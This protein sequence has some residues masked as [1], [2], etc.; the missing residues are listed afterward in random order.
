M[1]LSRGYLF[2]NRYLLV[3]LLGTG[4]SAQVWKAKDTRANN[5][6]VALKI[7]DEN[8][9]LNSFGLQNF[10]KQFTIVFNMK[11]SNLLPPTGYDIFQGRPYLVMQYCE[12]GSCTSMAGRTDEEDILKFLHDVAAGLEYLHDHN[13]I[14]QDIKPDNIMLDDNCNFLVTDFGISVSSTGNINDSEGMS[15]GTRRYMAPERYDGVTLPASDIWS[16]GASAVEL[17]T[18]NPPYGE[19]GGLL[20]AQGEP[21]PELP[22][23]LQPE[24]K[25]IIKSCLVEDPNHRIK[26]NEIRQKIELYWETGAWTKPSQKKTIA[27]V[28]TA[29]ASVLMC[30]GIFLWDYNR[31]KVYYYKDYVEVWGV[32]EGV[33][34]ISSWNAKHMHRLYRFEYKQRKVRRVSHVNSLDVIIFDTES[35]RSERPIDQDI[36]Y[37]SEGKVSRIKV[38]DNN[39]KVLYVK[40]FNENLTTMSFQYD[41]QHNTER[42]LAAQTVGYGRMLED[43]NSQKGKITRWLLEYNSDGYVTRVKYAG[44]D[45]SVVSDGNNIYGRTITYDSKGRISEIHYIGKNDEPQSTKWGLGIKKYYYDSEDNWIRAEYYTVDGQPAYDDSDGVG[46]YEME[47]DNNGNVVTIYHK[48]GN[49]ELMLPK[50]NGIAG[51]ITEY[52]DRGFIVKQTYIGTDK[53]PI[54]VSS[55]GFAGYTAKCDENG[56]FVEQEFFDPDGQVCETTEGNSKLVM[57]NDKYGNNLETWRYDIHGDLCLDPTG[58]AGTTYKYDSIG[59]VIEVVYYGKDKKPTLN[60]QGEAGLRLKYDERN[61]QTEMLTLDVN[62]NPAFDDNHICLVRHEYD[63]RGNT[64]KISFYNADGTQLVHSNENVAGWNILYDDLGNEIERSFFNDKNTLCEVIGG[65]AKKT[66]TFDQNGH[67]KSERFYNATGTLTTVNGIAGTDYVCDERGNVVVDKPISTNGTLAAG[68]VETH[69]KYD[70]FDNC[71]EESYFSNGNAADCLYGYHKAT[72]T[73][74]SRNQV[75]E[76]CY[77]NKNSQLTLTSNEGIAILKNEYDNRGNRIK[78][79]YYGTDSRPILGKEGWASSTYEFDAFGN[80]IKQCFFGIDGKPTDP[81]NMVPVG[82][83]K[84]DKHNNM[85]YIAAQD[86]NGKFIMNPNTGWAISRMEYDNR[87]H[88]LSQAYFD[89]HDKPMMGNNGCHKITYKY[90][91]NGNKTEEAYFGTDGK[92]IL[93]NG[94]HL[95]KYTYD[96][97]GNMTLYAL[98]DQSGKATNCAAGFHKIAVSYDN[99]T[100]VS[101]KYYTVS[102]SLLATQSY[103]KANGEWNDPQ[104]TGSVSSYSGSSYDWRS[105]VRKADSECPVE[106][107]DGIY[108]QSVTSSSSNVILTIKLAEISK[109][110]MTEELKSTLGEVTSQMRSYIRNALDLPSNVTVSV[111]FVDKANRTI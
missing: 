12:N 89:E 62:L 25:S 71:T 83:C 84:Y 100:P 33:G 13:I 93:V 104:G 7:F 87:S 40:A 46:I 14:H 39:G 68:R 61:L 98:Y 66:R 105:A 35:E 82:I 38:R 97:K 58:I 69:Y 47:Y 85:I 29:V 95:E 109:Y 43:N 70:K 26:A 55:A 18:N 15:G 9:D 23:K 111:N 107:A 60:E 59:N 52:D 77:Y 17:L 78:S 108:I 16:L 6:I 4:A 103:N 67:I 49:G 22:V 37:T 1:E 30:L 74:N 5:L 27:I 81:K 86:G 101:R 42:A 72:R 90:D 45:N 3:S 19:H 73:Y 57:V 11:H 91:V 51:A 102:G 50:K 64:T 99:G 36:Y 106:V 76:V 2:H 48:D 110:N 44:L 20:Q 65:Y 10:E 79:F 53:T 32:P 21:L 31:T 24:I 92:P 41:D 94:V 63:K 8:S 75:T 88:M 28:A 96:E 34:R 54:F 56:F 80:I